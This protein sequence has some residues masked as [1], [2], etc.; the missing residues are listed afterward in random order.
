MILVMP[1][2]LKTNPFRKKENE[3]YR[4]I[5]VVKSDS[6]TFAICERLEDEEEVNN[7]KSSRFKG[8][9]FEMDINALTVI[10]NNDDKEDELERKN[11]LNELHILLNGKEK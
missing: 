10:H 3:I 6:G 4:L 9:L 7:H 8:D 1:K 11:Y 2:W 5:N